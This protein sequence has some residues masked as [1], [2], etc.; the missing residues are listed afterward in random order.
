MHILPTIFPPA[1]RGAS[2]ARLMGGPIFYQ[3]SFP[4]PEDGHAGKGGLGIM[5]TGIR[6]EGFWGADCG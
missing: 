4:R 5:A 1:R 6:L 2:A 3:P